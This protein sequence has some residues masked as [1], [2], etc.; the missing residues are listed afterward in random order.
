ML[1]RLFHVIV[2][3]VLTFPTTESG[4]GPDVVPEYVN[5]GL[6]MIMTLVA[7]TAVLAPVFVIET[8]SGVVPFCGKVVGE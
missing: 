2:C 7:L 1:P 8:L 4:E 5:P 6:I 3:P